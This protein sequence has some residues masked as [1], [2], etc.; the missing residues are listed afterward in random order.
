M[1]IGSNEYLLVSIALVGMLAIIGPP[2]WWYG[3]GRRLGE[4][5][6]RKWGV[7]LFG[8]LLLMSV[9]YGQPTA[10]GDWLRWLVNM[11]RAVA[12]VWIIALGARGTSAK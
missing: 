5:R 4:R 11:G 6:E 2:I 7:I 1:N 3:R 10:K 12:G 8:V 9:G